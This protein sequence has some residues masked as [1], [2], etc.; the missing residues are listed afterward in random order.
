MNINSNTRKLHLSTAAPSP[1]TRY[2]LLAAFFTLVSWLPSPAQNVVLS[3]AIGG[4]VTDA[5]GAVV[6][7]VSVA[8]RNL[9]T[10]LEQ[11]ATTN[12]NGLYRFMGLMPG[13]YSVT[14]SGKGFHD[15]EA[16]VRVLVGNTTSQ[17]LRLQV[18]AERRH[19]KGHRGDA[20]S[21]ACGIFGQHRPGPL[22]H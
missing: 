20:A 22:V 10:G 6:P 5:S 19:D 21:A 7:G 16:L 14:A 2:V 8:V 9:A 12:H 1:L 13:T 17:D 18:G 3:G 15:I 4:R 11:S